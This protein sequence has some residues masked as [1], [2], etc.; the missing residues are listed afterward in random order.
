MNQIAL[1]VGWA[2]ALPMFEEVLEEMRELSKIA[3][4]GW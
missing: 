4:R 3:K 1:K 2:K